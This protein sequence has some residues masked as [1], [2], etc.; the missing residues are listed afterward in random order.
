[1]NFDPDPNDEIFRFEQRAFIQQTLSELFPDRQPKVR[2]AFDRKTAQKW[3]GALNAKGYAV[4]RW[5]AEFGG[6]PWTPRQCSIFSDEMVA[7]SAPQMDAIGIGFVGPVICQ[8]GSPEQQKRYLPPIC[9]G[10]EFWC[11]GF[12]EPGAGSDA[13]LL[14]TTATREGDFF[15]VNGRKLWITNGHCADMMFALVRID[16]PG[17]RRQ[18]G[19]SCLMID[20]H[21]PGISI[22]P[23]ILVDGIHRVN[24][25][26]LN[27]VRVPVENLVG[28]QGKGWVYSRF[29]LDRERTIVAGLPVLRRQITSVRTALSNEKRYDEPLMND[30]LYQTRLA[31]L[32]VELD[33]L[34]FLELRIQHASDDD[35][36]TQV[37]ASMLKLRGS[38]LRQRVSELT[39]EVTGERALEFSIAPAADGVAEPNLGNT[40]WSVINYLFQRSA[41]LVGGTSEIQRNI[42]SSMSLGL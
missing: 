33:A 38:E 12:S 28:E 7:A 31:Q 11:Q 32:E 18:Q 42:I 27:N 3:T 23:V 25:V 9:N 35:S 37:L 24:E 41:T 6:A 16:A 34:E 17:N 15:V 14:R 29:L 40:H 36:G 26:T 39:W 21:T 30:P 1:M 22:Q 4:P 5:P 2:W 19:L 20:M 10:D 8:F 13:M